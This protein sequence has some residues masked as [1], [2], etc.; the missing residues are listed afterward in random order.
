MAVFNY[1]AGGIG[2]KGT[3]I[4]F[5]GDDNTVTVIRFPADTSVTATTLKTAPDPT[6]TFQGTDLDLADAAVAEAIYAIVNS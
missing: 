4:T 3:V 6:Q 1:P 5:V 2:A